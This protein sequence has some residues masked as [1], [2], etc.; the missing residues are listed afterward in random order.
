MCRGYRD[1]GIVRGVCVIRIAATHTS[2]GLFLYNTL[3]NAGVK[4]KVAKCLEELDF[5]VMCLIEDLKDD[6]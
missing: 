1:L 4:N 5:G 2:G 3:N 6:L